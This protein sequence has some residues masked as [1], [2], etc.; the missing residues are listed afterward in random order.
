MKPRRPAGCRVALAGG[1]LVL[2][3]MAALPTRAAG[4]GAASVGPAP[5]KA[6]SAFVE[7]PDGVKI[8]YLEAGTGRAILFV[9][10]WTMTAEIWEPQLAHFGK[11]WRA[12]A[13][14]PRG[15]GESGKPE[16]GLYPAARARDI[17]AVVDALGLAPV[18]LV[19]WSMGVPE[20]AAFVD[21]F[22]TKDLA[23]VVLVDGIAGSDW[24][25]KVSPGMIMW[26]G[27]F[28]RDRQAQTA[29][30]VRFMYRT[31]QS[32]AY[33]QTITALSLKTPTP[34][35]V[36]LFVGTM[37]SDLRPALAK[38]DKPTLLAVAPGSGF[39]PV[40][41]KMR[42]SIPGVRFEKF[43]GAGHAL[44]VDQPARFNA[45]IEELFG[46]AAR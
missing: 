42:Q 22:G 23:G 9:P 37:T 31:P 46:G 25:P 33:L 30:F 39:D 17:K 38:I 5:A 43:D 12:V 13:I 4:Q 8:R 28:L 15:Q 34:T 1:A 2:A 27:G 32:E 20:V 3:S 45:L 7:T 6:K 44:F 18:V 35:A 10:G 19:G 14:D 36:A 40:Y 26:T 24:D 41:E 29:A 21:Q 16:H 11:A